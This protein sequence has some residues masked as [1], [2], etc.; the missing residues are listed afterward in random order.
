MTEP[1]VASSPDDPRPLSD[2]Q[3]IINQLRAIAER[4]TQGSSKEDQHIALRALELLARERGLFA[5]P[6]QRPRRLSDLP[7]EELRAAL[8][9]LEPR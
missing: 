8:A 5:R 4:A 9:R 6:S 7:V 1:P 2:S 3:W